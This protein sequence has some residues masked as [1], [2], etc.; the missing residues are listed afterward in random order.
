MRSARAENSGTP[1]NGVK[2]RNQRLRALLQER[3]EGRTTEDGLGLA[4]RLHLLVPRRLADVEVLQDEAARLVQIS[5]LVLV[6][7]L[8]VHRSLLRLLGRGLVRLRSRLEL[9]LV[10]DVAVLLLDGAVRVLHERLIRLL[11]VRLRLDGVG[12][13]LLRIRDDLL[14][15]AHHAA[16][17]RGLL[18]LLE[19]RRRR[20]ARR[21]LRRLLLHEGLLRVH[22]LEH[23]ERVRQE[24]LRLAL[25]RDRELE[26]RVLLLAVLARALELRLHLR[27]LRLQRRDGLGELVDGRREVGDLRLE[28]VDVAGLELLRALVL[29][30]AVRAEVLVLDLVLLLLEERGH[31]L[32]NRGLHLGERVEAH[33]RGERRE[34]R[35]RIRLRRR[36]EHLRGLVALGVRL[37]AGHLHEVEG[38]RESVVRVVAGEDRQGLAARL[39]LLLARLL[40]L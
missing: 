16:G 37:L 31:H 14:E 26:V 35:V 39:D 5:L 17:A 3:R 24:L 8:L 2:C 28:L 22:G 33:L 1:A 36:E 25:V 4:Q 18:V 30:Q 10:R 29:V 9:G 19:A 7:L 12:L 27:N 38:L 32:V 21:L 34:L 23:V 13:E 40:A 11:G 6:L 20:R 15:H